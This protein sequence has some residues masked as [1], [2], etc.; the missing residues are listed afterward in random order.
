MLGT[1]KDLQFWVNAIRNDL[2]FENA[3]SFKDFSRSTIGQSGRFKEKATASFGGNGIYNVLYYHLVDSDIT[4]IMLSN[5]G[6]YPSEDYLGDLLGFM[7]EYRDAT[8]QG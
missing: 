3:Q 2:F 7:K 5:T 1:A 6:E 8:N 4:L